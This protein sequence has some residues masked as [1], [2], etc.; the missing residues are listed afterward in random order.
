MFEEMNNSIREGT[1]QMLLTFVFR[2]ERDVE[3]KQ[4][5]TVTSTSG[6]SDGSEEKKRPVKK[7]AKVG[8]NDPCPCG[9]GKKYKHC[10][11]R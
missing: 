5:V 7:A 11:G 4:T 8:R 9:S 3:R 1:V 2:S 6:A 10:C